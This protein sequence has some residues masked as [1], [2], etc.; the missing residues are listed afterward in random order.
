MTEKLEPPPLTSLLAVQTVYDLKG[1]SW[2]D[3][4]QG[5]AFYHC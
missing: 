4:S 5:L 2:I 3:G 1:G